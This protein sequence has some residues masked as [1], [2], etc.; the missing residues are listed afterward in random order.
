MSLSSANSSLS[1]VISKPTWCNFDLTPAS[2]PAHR[3]RLVLF[4]R[5]IGDDELTI[6]QQAYAKAGISLGLVARFAVDESL[7]EALACVPVDAFMSINQE[8]R[9]K[10]RKVAKQYSLQAV[11]IDN[12]PTILQPGLLVMDMDSTAI[13]IECIDEIAR[14]ANV[15]DEVAAVTKA[16]MAGQLAFS[17]SLYQRVAKLKGIEL[18]LLDTIRFDLPLMPGITELCARLKQHGWRLAIASGG[19]TLFAEQL[20]EVLQ[21]DDVVANELEFDGSELSG[22][23]LGAVVDAEKKRETL[24]ALRTKYAIPNG[25][26]VA[27]GDGANDL[28]MMAEAALGVAVH[29][30]EKVVTEAD[31]AICHGSLTQLLY[32]LSTP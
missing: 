12:P 18:S 8:L 21:L 23:V 14:L 4:G 25:Q 20:R 22:R 15:Y 2:A 19:F 6:I 31:A 16:A 1:Q 5:V 27:M 32:L 13:T 7:P 11:L 9:S 29:G 10:V 17:E 28:L 24:A 30:K 26:T 3:Q